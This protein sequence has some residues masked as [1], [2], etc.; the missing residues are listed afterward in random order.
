MDCLDFINS[1]YMRFGI[2]DKFRI[3]GFQLTVN[4]FIENFLLKTRKINLIWKIF[5]IYLCARLC[6]N[7]KKRKG[8][9]AYEYCLEKAKSSGTVNL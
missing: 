7:R 5:H 4:S 6:Y 8:F 3:N 9:D 1:C 2:F